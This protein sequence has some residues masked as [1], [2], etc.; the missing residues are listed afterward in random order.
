MSK[1]TSS[2][3]RGLKNT[4][5]PAE[6]VDTYPPAVWSF[7]NAVAPTDPDHFTRLQRLIHTWIE[8]GRID[9]PDTPK[10]AEKLERVTS[11]PAGH[12]KQ[13]IDDLD[14]RQAMLGDLR[15]KLSFMKRDLA[16]LLSVLHNP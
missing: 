15:A 9:P 3:L 13:T 5:R 10:G 6:P 8:V 12:L 11:A 16:I 4:Y 7:L 1:G 2:V 14:D